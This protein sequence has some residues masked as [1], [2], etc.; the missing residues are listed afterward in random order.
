MIIHLH[1]YENLNYHLV[2]DEMIYIYFLM[3]IENDIYHLIC[4]N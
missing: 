2:Q 1:Y 3:N 4:M